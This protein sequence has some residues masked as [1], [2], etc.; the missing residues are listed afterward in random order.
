M[1]PCMGRR[2][3]DCNVL[4]QQSPSRIFEEGERRGLEVCILIVILQRVLVGAF[5]IL[6]SSS[7]ILQLSD[8]SSQLSGIICLGFEW[9]AASKEVRLALKRGTV[10]WIMMQSKVW[11]VACAPS[12]TLFLPCH[13]ACPRQSSNPFHVL[14]DRRL[15]SAPMIRDPSCTA[16]LLS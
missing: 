11:S 1:R 9:S 16:V 8:V 6:E 4:S 14:V 13:F 5:H 3:A 12:P 10:T 7:K 15:S 2:V